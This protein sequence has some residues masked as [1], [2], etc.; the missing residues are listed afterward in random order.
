M[1]FDIRSQVEDQLSTSL[2]E[3]SSVKKLKKGDKFLEDIVGQYM[4]D[5]IT[6]SK[7]KDV[8]KVQ[9]L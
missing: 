6:K 7:D 4:F 1:S 5:K 9:Q 2:L 8:L 3:T